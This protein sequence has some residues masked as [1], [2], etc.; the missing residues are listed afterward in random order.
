MPDANRSAL[1]MTDIPGSNAKGDVAEQVPA[2][3]YTILVNE[4]NRPLRRDQL[5]RELHQRN[6][7]MA[8]KIRSS[9]SNL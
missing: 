4:E 2:T 6:I 3:L 8:G 1:R 9:V 5:M 7:G